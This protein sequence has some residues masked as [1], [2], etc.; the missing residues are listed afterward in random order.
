[1][2]NIAV[3]GA[4][5]TMGRPIARNLARAGFE[6]RAWNRTPERMAPLADEGIKVSASQAEAVEGAG[7]VLTVLSDADAVASSMAGVLDGAG[8]DTI[9][10]QMSTIGIAGTE[11]CAQLAKETGVVFVDAPVLGTKAPAEKGELVVLASGPD[12]ARARLEPLFEA[13]GKRTMWLGE[14]GTGSRLKVVVNSWILALVEGVAETI[15]LAEGIDL[16]PELFLEA[17]AG[18]PMDV[19]YAQM[20]GKAM[21]ERDF[22]PSFKLRLASKDAAL[23]EEAVQRHGLDLPLVAT[24]RR[25][26][27]DGVEAHGDED[28]AATYLTSAA[29]RAVPG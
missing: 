21:I 22:E 3:I 19:P 29:E 25:R 1:M 23:V 28:M 14:A 16:R 24:I 13:I 8:P 27:E 7:L 9:W 10:L 20:K 17:I 12:G 15:A 5:G 18:G 6:V 2:D 4:G 11:H 26:L